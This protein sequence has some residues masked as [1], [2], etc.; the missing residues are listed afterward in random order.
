MG[1]EGQGREGKE[2]EWEDRGRGEGGKGRE[3]RAS[4][5]AAALGLAKL[6]AG[7]VV[8]YQRQLASQVYDV[9]SQ[10]K[11]LL[12]TTVIVLTQRSC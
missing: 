11:N 9:F 10:R 4:H 5:T 12:E 6:R 3:E 8:C 1:G 2:R 7:P